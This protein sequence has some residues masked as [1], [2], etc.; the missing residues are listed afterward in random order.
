MEWVCWTAT[1]WYG[2]ERMPLGL[3]VLVRHQVNE[4][5]KDV[6]EEIHALSMKTWTPEQYEKKKAAQ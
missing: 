4:A 5:L 3:T 2:I 6:M 1:E